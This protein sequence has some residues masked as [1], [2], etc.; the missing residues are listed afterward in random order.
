MRRQ[1]LKRVSCAGV[2]VSIE[3]VDG[4][5]LEQCMF[6][7]S[8]ICSSVVDCFSTQYGYTTFYPHKYWYNRIL[9]NQDINYIL[10]SIR[11]K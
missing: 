2:S 6:H 11:R 5:G 8:I 7:H 1:A 9:F 3:M 4:E 10:C